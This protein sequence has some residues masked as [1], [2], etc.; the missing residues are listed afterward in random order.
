[1]SWLGLLLRNLWRRPGRSLF[2]L[3]GV[4]IALASFI[5]L[6]GLSRGLGQAARASLDERGIHLLVIRRGSVEFFSAILPQSLGERIAAIP[7]VTAVSPELSNLLPVGEDGHALVAGW[8]AG[9]FQWQGLRLLHGR[10]PAPGEHGVVLGEALAAALNAEVGSTVEL[11]LEPFPVLG[12]AGFGAAL[13][14]GMAMLPL[15]QMQRLLG[16][17]AQV[18]LFHLQVERPGDRAAAEAVRTAILALRRDLAVVTSDEVLKGNRSVATFNSLAN[19]LALA[20]LV[21]AG[22]SVLNTLAMAVEERTREIGVLA[23]IGWSRGRILRLVLGE[24]AALAVL[25]GLLGTLLGEGALAALN[26]MVLQGGTQATG[27]P[28]V[29]AEALGFGV[30]VGLLGALWPAWRAT[31]I[32]P[33]AAMRRG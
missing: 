19:A 29:I 7:G 31:R 27:G 26:A 23:A 24:G 21:L 25:G 9:G 12:I 2:T 8:P 22:F 6:T 14:R 1:M 32:S 4:A 13:N 28:G 20:A 11:N 33:A 18:T 16:R 15:P 10:L 3:F 17:D 5:A 30:L